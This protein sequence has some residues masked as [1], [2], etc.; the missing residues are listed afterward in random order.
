[1]LI[2]VK[3]KHNNIILQIKDII[4]NE[5]NDL[6]GFLI[7]VTSADDHDFQQI[8]YEFNNNSWNEEVNVF[9]S[10]YDVYAF[11]SVLTR[12]LY[13]VG[14]DISNDVKTYF[15]NKFNFTDD[16]FPN[17]LKI[18]YNYFKNIDV[19]YSGI[20]NNI[21]ELNQLLENGVNEMKQQIQNNS[22]IIDQNLLRNVILFDKYIT[23]FFLTFLQKIYRNHLIPMYNMPLI[24]QV[25]I[26]NDDTITIH[27]LLDSDD[28]F[29]RQYKLP[30]PF[31][32]YRLISSL[33]EIIFNTDYYNNVLN[34]KVM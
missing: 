17:L 11:L 18:F 29:I 5:F 4:T 8:K 14:S 22:F 28:N 9:N 33:Y 20:E 30:I 10:I 26:N 2:E 24:T 12:D 1:M 7:D 19:D 23:H 3:E 13:S 6:D 31:S 21:T 25:D 27:I 15:Q 34:E 32:N 16:E